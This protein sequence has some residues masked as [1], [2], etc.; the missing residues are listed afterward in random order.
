MAK[1]EGSRKRDEPH[2]VWGRKE[3]GLTVTLSEEG[4]KLAK[5]KATKLGISVSEVIERWARGFDVS[6]GESQP[7]PPELDSKS[8]IFKSMTT[9]EIHEI[10]GQK[11]KTQQEEADRS[12][13]QSEIYQKLVDA[14]I[15]EKLTNVDIAKFA[16]LLDLDESKA[17]KLMQ[18]TKLLKGG[19]RTNGV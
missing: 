7:L 14:L 9:A 3:K 8:E 6:F 16:G 15:E 2:T 18:L 5:E 4:W 10:L 11:L 19:K 17:E 1:R 12:K 13:Q